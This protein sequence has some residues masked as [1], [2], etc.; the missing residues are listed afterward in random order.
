METNHQ[1]CSYFSAHSAQPHRS[2]PLRLL[3]DHR[4]WNRVDR[5]EFA[6]AALARRLLVSEGDGRGARVHRL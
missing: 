4:R 1:S 2:F 6:K 5:R 3:E